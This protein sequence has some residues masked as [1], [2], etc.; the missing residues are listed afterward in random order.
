[1]ELHVE[2]LGRGYAWLDTGTHDSLVEAMEFVR[3][4]Q[5][6]QGVAIAC[7]EE[8]A[9]RMGF[10]DRGQLL[11]LAEPLLKSGYGEHLM[12]VAREHAEPMREGSN[13]LAG[14]EA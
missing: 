7:V 8:V 9:Y 13:W 4:I 1:G 5:H 12:R 11:S 3:T 6:R 2:Q 10:I 14:T